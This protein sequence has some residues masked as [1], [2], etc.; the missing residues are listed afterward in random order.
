MM[1]STQFFLKLMRF[2]TEILDYSML[3]SVLLNW[4]LPIKK[5]AIRE[6]RTKM[7]TDYFIFYF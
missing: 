5:L 3:R 2:I 7:I 1:F 6:N 4:L